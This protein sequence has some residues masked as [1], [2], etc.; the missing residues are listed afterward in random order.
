MRGDDV[1]RVRVWDPALRLFHWA[2]ATLVIANWTLGKLGPN[3]MSLHFYLGYAII[4]LLVFRM[5]WGIVGPAPARFGSFLRGPKGIV[6]YSR[7]MTRRAPSHW[8]GHTPLG[9][10]WVIAMLAVLV[11]QICTGL[12]SDPEDFINVGPLADKVGSQTAT[13]AV[14]WHHLGSDLILILVLL[15]LAVIL[16]Y[17]FWKNEDLIGPMISGWKW[18]RRR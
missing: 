7:R 8:H 4:A 6:E 16:F 2:L 15:H 17:R 10:L 13:G 18:V 14:G 9:G 5:I 11:G 1:Q 3:D 12:I